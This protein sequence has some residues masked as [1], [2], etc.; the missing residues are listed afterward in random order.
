MNSKQLLGEQQRASLLYERK[1]LEIKAA[2]IRTEAAELKQ[3][4]RDTQR[5]I[6]RLTFELNSN[7]S[8][9]PPALKIVKP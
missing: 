6:R 5:R 9:S 8:C 1:C 4:L 3:E 2:Q 7:L